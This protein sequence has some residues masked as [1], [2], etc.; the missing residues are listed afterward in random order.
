ME[1]QL[2]SLVAERG[3]LKARLTRFKR[4]VETSSADMAIGALERKTKTY[5]DLHTKFDKVQAQIE[6]IVAGSDSE[7]V[8]LE[9]REEFENTFFV[10]MNKV[11]NYILDL[12]GPQRPV[13][14]PSTLSANITDSQNAP[15]LPTIVLPNFDG[16]YDHWDASQWPSVQTPTQDVPEVRKGNATCLALTGI[17]H[18]P[19]DLFSR[20]SSYSKLRRV[21]AYCLRFSK[22]MLR[23]TK[24]QLPSHSDQPSSLTL[25]T[26][27]LI[28]AERILVR[29]AQ[30][31]QFKSDIALL[32]DNK[33]LTRS[34]LKSLN[35]FIDEMGVIRVGGR[36]RNAPIS[37]DQRHP[38]ILPAKHPLTTLIVE[39]E[40]RRL[41]H[42]GHQLTLSSIR[43]RFWPITGKRLINQ[44]LSKCIRC[45]R[46][47]PTSQMYMMGD[48]PAARVSPARA[49]STCGVDYAGPFLLKER[50]RSRVTYKS[51][52]CIFV[53]FTT[54]A[55]HIELAT[56]LSTGAFLNCLH[57]FISRRGRSHCIYSDNGTNFVGARKELN[58]LG[59]LL[60]TVEHNN[61]IQNILAQEQIQWR[62]IP[63]YS[64][65]F[66]GLWEGAVKSVKHHLKRVIG[67]QRLT[68]EE[69]YTI[70]TQVEACLNSRPLYPL[71][72]DPTDLSPLTPGH[73]LIGDA[74][75]APP[76][77]DLL[78]I[79]INRLNRYQLIQH[80]VQQFWKRW[81]RE[82]L[83]ELQQRHKWQLDSPGKLKVGSLVVIRD[84]NTPPLRWQLGRI[85][86]LHPGADGIPRVVSVKVAEGV[87][88]RPVTRICV[89]PTAETDSHS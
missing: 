7:E 85:V 74:V 87:F 67:E 77:R 35:P 31:E 10:L 25:T 41:L 82:Y 44:V 11:D 2:K 53:C 16:R 40:H 30:R 19:F 45:F 81:H 24:R 88:K 71:S 83:H 89:L 78:H 42:S 75:I 79:K 34:N 60:N 43:T 70:L 57:R 73:F 28:D 66:G 62:F 36:L 9:E 6:T 18:K 84:D 27:E 12:R 51:Y 29:L 38:M 26:R 1:A 14:S 86:D 58:E 63:P 17:A 32:T 49:F 22:A 56:D 55:V 4:F 69:L 50:G 37:Y 52:I 20:Y 46:V 13:A 3:G 39:Y 76:H 72:S 80:S 59:S 68:F 54:K 61:R 15:R 65:H 47:H 48:L 21:T 64:P 23:T 5:E 33:P 8:Q